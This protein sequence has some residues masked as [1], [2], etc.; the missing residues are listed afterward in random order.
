MNFL[1]PVE[2]TMIFYK[3]QHRIIKPLEQFAAHFRKDRRHPFPMNI[4]LFEKYITRSVK[5]IFNYFA[6]KTNKGEITIVVE[7]QQ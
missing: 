4:K 3:L 6:D 2:H 7:G 1:A 5:A